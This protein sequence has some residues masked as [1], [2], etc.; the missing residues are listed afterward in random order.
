MS[1]TSSHLSPK[2]L[3]ELGEQIYRT[4]FKEEYERDH[5]GKFVAINV[6]SSSATIG[7]TAEEA[8]VKAKEAD[9][10]ALFY[11]IRIGYSG[12]FQ[13]GRYASSDPDWLFR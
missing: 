11:L 5:H 1:T 13:M 3:T 4:K 6:R 2:L 9:P 8:L 12:A 10:K 7:E